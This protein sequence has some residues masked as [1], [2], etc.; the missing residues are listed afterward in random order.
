[1]AQFDFIKKQSGDDPILLLDD[2]FDKLD[3]RR[4]ELL[5]NILNTGDFGQIFITDTSYERFSILMKKQS[6][7]HQI[8]QVDNGRII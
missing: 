5:M 3:D 4:V 8:I 6:I 1:M 7:E 2:I